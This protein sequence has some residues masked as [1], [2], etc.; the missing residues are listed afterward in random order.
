MSRLNTFKIPINQALYSE[1]A[2]LEEE[3]LL[4]LLLGQLLSYS[5]V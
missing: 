3:T 2:L 5:G 4:L 1:L